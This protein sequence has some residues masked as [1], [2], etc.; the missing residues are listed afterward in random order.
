M[1]TDHKTNGGRGASLSRRGFLRVAKLATCSAG[2]A[3]T[4]PAVA[5]AGGSADL[6]TLPLSID[7]AALIAAV[8]KHAIVS[9]RL[10]LAEKTYRVLENRPDRPPYPAVAFVDVAERKMDYPP[11][12]IRY[13]FESEGQI[14]AFFK[15]A[16]ASFP[17]IFSAT[18]IERIK[19]D[20]RRAEAQL[21]A[22][23]ESFHRWN[24]DSGLLDLGEEISDLYEQ[25][26]QLEEEISSFPCS[27]PRMAALKAKFAVDHVTDRIASDHSDPDRLV[28][29]DALLLV[30]ML[31]SMLPLME[32]GA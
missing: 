10:E 2:I 14:E 5:E 27:S 24:T 20:W 15:S 9:S 17:S 16:I 25:K 30:A 21:L 22:M 13:Q 12:C 31:K 4:L 26:D 19:S 32:E 6:P 29:C 23:R 28:D 7:E 18:Y 1:H 3:A 8:N 11:C